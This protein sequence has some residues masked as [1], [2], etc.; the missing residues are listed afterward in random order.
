MVSKAAAPK[1][2]I[3][4]AIQ[5]LISLGSVH[6]PFQ[7]HQ[8]QQQPQPHILASQ[9]QHHFATRTTISTK[10]SSARSS[11]GAA[12]AARTSYS[13]S[14]RQPITTPLISSQPVRLFNC[15]LEVS[16]KT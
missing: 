13:Q 2:Q 3:V 8:Q 12:R 9:P 14:G 10:G 1:L 6:Q 7:H 15:F 5:L 11:T 4:H 16:R